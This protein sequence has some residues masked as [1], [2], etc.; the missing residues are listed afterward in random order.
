MLNEIWALDE[1]KISQVFE[2]RDQI[3]KPTGGLV[4]QVI[5]E[6][7]PQRRLKDMTLV[8]YGDDTIRVE[9]FPF[10]IGKSQKASYTVKGDKYISRKHCR[11][12]VR[13]DRFYI[14]DLDSLNGTKVDGKNIE[15]KTEIFDGSEIMLADRKYI[16]KWED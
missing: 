8:L 12:T 5:K 1:Q 16:A 9:S 7:I 4:E 6:E 15:Q 3:L 14:E 13:D 2:T 11:L 10:V